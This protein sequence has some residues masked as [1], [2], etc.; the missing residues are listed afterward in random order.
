MP[1]ITIIE[2]PIVEAY[3][4]SSGARDGMSGSLQYSVLMDVAKSKGLDDFDD[5]L[6]YANE[7]ERLL[8]KKRECS[9][10]TK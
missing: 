7:M 9:K 8:S 4:L 2:Q 1:E 3:N 6:Y 10:K 5:V